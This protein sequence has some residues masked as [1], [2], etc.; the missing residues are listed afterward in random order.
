MSSLCHRLKALLLILPLAWMAG[1]SGSTSRA[2]SPPPERETGFPQGYSSAER[3]SAE[4]AL[5]ITVLGIIPS[6][7]GYMLDF[8]Y[9]V[10][11]PDKSGPMFVRKTIPYL[12]HEETGAKYMVP[13]PAKIGPMRQTTRKPV[14]DNH[15][16][17]FFANP[18]K[19]VKP[20]DLVTVVV[21]AYRFPHLK[22]L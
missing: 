13:A 21:G 1:C 22:V 10:D 3:S 20:G 9:R 8:R 17:I 11:E 6:S 16:F 5:G 4:I 14:A 15:Y 7:G 2:L 18:G 12:I 19:A